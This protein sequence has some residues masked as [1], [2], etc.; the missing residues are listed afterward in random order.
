MKRMQKRTAKAAKNRED[1]LYLSIL[2]I[3][4]LILYILK[5]RN[6]Y[7]AGS[8]ID[9]LGQHI[10]FPDYFRKLFYN[11]GTLFPQFAAELG[12]G[13][14]IYNFAYYGLFNPVYLLSYAL[15]FVK[16]AT[17]IQVVAFLEHI[18]DGILC[19]YWLGRGHFR[20]Q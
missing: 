17:Y 20:R 11:T 12:G 7:L 9:W 8:E 13:Q 10:A 6:G 15:P 3:I 5:T 18:A 4:P 2:I 19:Y 1:I 14:N 16:M